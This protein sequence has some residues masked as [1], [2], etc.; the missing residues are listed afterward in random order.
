[1]IFVSQGFLIDDF[2][3]N[4]YKQQQ[5]IEEDLGNNI[6]GE[7]GDEV[8]EELNINVDRH[9]PPE[10]I[11]TSIYDPSIDENLYLDMKRNRPPNWDDSTWK[12]AAYPEK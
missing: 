5:P 4:N 2:Q 1:M 11:D 7:D 10:D 12:Y 3:E 6:E 8:E 9:S